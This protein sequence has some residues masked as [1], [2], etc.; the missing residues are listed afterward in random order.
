[1]TKIPLTASKEYPAEINPHD[2]D[3]F[4]MRFAGVSSPKAGRCVVK[5]AVSAHCLKTIDLEAE[6]FVLINSQCMP[7]YI[8]SK[9]HQIA[10]KNTF[11]YC[12]YTAHFDKY[13]CLYLVSSNRMNSIRE[14]C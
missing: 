9:I 5:G 14:C 12:V 1:M 8:H 7:G 4:E 6:I 10:H 13:N 2:S 3:G 11:Q